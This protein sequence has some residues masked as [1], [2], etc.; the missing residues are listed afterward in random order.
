MLCDLQ[1]EALLN[2]QT[3]LYSLQRK[4]KTCRQS[5][6]NKELHLGLLQKKVEQLQASLK[7]AS[8]RET[9]CKASVS[10]VTEIKW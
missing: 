5:E 3:A 6:Q 2:K 8:L 9:E 10:K 1:S 7:A 4:L